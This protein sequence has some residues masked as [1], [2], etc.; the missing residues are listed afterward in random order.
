[1]F[2]GTQGELERLSRFVV[3]LNETSS[4][5]SAGWNG[6]SIRRCQSPGL[7]ERCCGTISKWFE[8]RRRFAMRDSRGRLGN[9]DGAEVVGYGLNSV[10]RTYA[11]YQGKYG[12]DPRTSR[13]ISPEPLPEGSSL[14]LIRAYV[15]GA[16]AGFAAANYAAQ[17]RKAEFAHRLRSRLPP[18]DVADV[19]DVA[20]DGLRKLVAGKQPSPI[21]G[22]RKLAVAQLR[23]NPSDFEAPS[24][25]FRE[26][27]RA[28]LAGAVKGGDKGLRR[29]SMWT[30]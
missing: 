29:K 17:L 20:P 11:L 21:T 3:Y 10:G 24:K 13:L 22:N 25:G 4:I 30:G 18:E 27:L 6:P 1:M 28:A 15:V 23:L 7:A 12:A 9:P 5:S 8:R 14:E 2:N 26:R 16:A 19:L